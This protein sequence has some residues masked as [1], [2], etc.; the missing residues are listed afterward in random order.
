MTVV[1][2]GA[3]AGTAVLAALKRSEIVCLLCDRDIERN[4]VPVDFFGEQ[5]TL[6]AGPATLGLRIGAPI[7]PVACYFTPQY[8]GHHALVPWV[9][10]ALVFNIIAAVLLLMPRPL[11]RPRLLILACARR[12]G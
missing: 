4:G 3:G 12:S 5:T 11:E 7:L 8:N 9:W 1:P 10:T 6:P 2:T